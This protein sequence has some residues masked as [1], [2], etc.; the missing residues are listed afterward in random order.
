MENSL[1]YYVILE[2]LTYERPGVLS[3]SLCQI[4]RTKDTTVVSILSTLVKKANKYVSQ[5]VDL[6][7]R[8][9]NSLEHASEN[10]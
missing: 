7:L 10:E 1:D 6:F 4:N 5:N 2:I 3:I 9:K 8:S